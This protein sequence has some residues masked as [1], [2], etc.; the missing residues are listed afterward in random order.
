M[1]RKRHIRKRRGT[2][3][4][5]ATSR[6]AN[7]ARWA[8]DRARRDAEEPARLRELAEIEAI[9]LPRR[10]GDVIGCLQWTDYGTGRVRRWT[11]RRGD[12]SDRMTVHSP[13]GRATRSHG[14]TWILNH[15]R[16]FL[17]GTK[18]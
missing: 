17:A 5:S 3:W 10:P 13:D 1:T 7:A 4:T 14:W 16:G 8:A 6:R 11:V 2:P 12:R 18:S 9:N 15:L